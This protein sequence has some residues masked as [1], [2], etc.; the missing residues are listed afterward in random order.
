MAEGAEYLGRHKF[1]NNPD[2]YYVY[3]ATLALYQHQG[4][5]WKEWNDKLKD[6]FPRIQN[7]IGNNRGS[8]DP[9]GRHANA[10]GRVVSTTLSVLSLEVYYRLLPMYGFRGASDLPDAKKRGQ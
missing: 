5:V 9:G 3:Y 4:P 10:G 1:N 8:W 7:K 6:T 2:Y